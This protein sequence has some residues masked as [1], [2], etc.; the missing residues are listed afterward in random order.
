MKYL[1]GNQIIKTLLSENV[2]SLNNVKEISNTLMP[3]DVNTV[4]SYYRTITCNYMYSQ[5]Q[6]LIISY[7]NYSCDFLVLEAL[8]KTFL[9][10]DIS[11]KL[12]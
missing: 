11:C 3:S 1:L 5:Y 4:I 2:N 6:I 8:K 9:S 7:F 10:I 12:F